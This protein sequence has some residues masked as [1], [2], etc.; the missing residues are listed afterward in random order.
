MKKHIILSLL[1]FII[2][3]AGIAQRVI[4]SPKVEAFTHST[5]FID[6]VIL[7]DT[8]TTLDF[9]IRYKPRN[10]IIFAKDNYIINSDGGN[11]LYCKAAIGYQ[12]NLGDKW[13][14]PDSGVVH[15]SLIYPPINPKTEKIDFIETE[16]SEGAFKI[17]GIEINSSKRQSILP[18]EMEGNWLKTDGSNE[19]TFGFYDKLAI[20]K[21]DFW[22]YQSVLKQGKSIRMVLK[23]GKQIVTL[24]LL[25][26]ADNKMMISDGKSQMLAYSRKKTTRSDYKV[27]SEPAFTLLPFGQKETTLQGYMKGYSPKLGFKNDLIYLSNDLTREDFPAL[28][29]F[30]PDGRF[31][32]KFNLL[33]PQIITA[34]IGGELYNIYLEP[35]DKTMLYLNYKPKAEVYPRLSMGSHARENEELNAM[36]RIAERNYSVFQKDKELSPLDF[37][38]KQLKDRQADIEALNAFIQHNPVSPK[39]LQ[40]KKLHIDTK[41]YGYILDYLMRLRDNGNNDSIKQVLNDVAYYDFLKELLLHQNLLPLTDDFSSV[42]NRLEYSPIINPDNFTGMELE[43]KALSDIRFSKKNIN[44][45]NGEYNVPAIIEVLEKMKI[46]LT[47][48]EQQTLKQTPPEFAQDSLRFFS[49]LN[50]RDKFY[51]KHQTLINILFRIHD[52]DIQKAIFKQKLGVEPGLIFEIIMLRELCLQFKTT[53]LSPTQIDL[54]KPLFKIPFLQDELVRVNDEKIVLQNEKTLQPKSPVTSGERVFHK[55][56]EQYKGNVLAIDFWS[57]GCGPCRSGM[58]KRKDMPDELKNRKVKFIYITDQESSPLEPYHNFIKDIKGEHLRITR[59]EWNQLAAQYKING[60]P[61]FMIMNKQGAV[62]EN[63][64]RYYWGDDLKKRLEELEKE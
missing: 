54:L 9:T 39:A 6:R 59:D 30:Q 10:W 52:F 57:T 50:I 56:I 40:I 11:K 49:Y 47:T 51:A 58:T 8:A 1:L 4:R 63:N 5:V 12:S 41:C 14:M 61:H 37:K 33:Y 42:I 44:R 13:Y 48:E 34:R 21:N 35:G 32:A 43:H 38:E 7:S 55:L 24:N 64:A 17:F 19:W 3:Q 62:I 22:Q 23:N 45:T 60:I 28:L 15:F 27:K 53:P 2:C 26:V 36:K 29:T 20:Y 46:P 31:E 16:K 25:P 18:E